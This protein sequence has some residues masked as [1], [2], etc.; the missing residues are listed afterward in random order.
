M[1]AIPILLVSGDA[2]RSR[3]LLV[4]L[5]PFSVEAYLS[6]TVREARQAMLRKTFGMVFCDVECSDGGYAEIL[7]ACGELCP[8]AAVVVTSRREDARTYLDAMRRGAFDFILWPY[9]PS[10]VA[11]IVRTALET[12]RPRA[13]TADALR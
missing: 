5:E 10:E 7:Q 12:K 4:I 6:Q 13:R 1:G 9:C 2:L 3:E 11:R 8:E